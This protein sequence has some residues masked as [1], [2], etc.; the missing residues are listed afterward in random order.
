MS[1]NFITDIIDADI[2]AGLDSARVATRFPPEPNG[3][4]HIGHAKS[5]CLNFG[6]AQR[7]GGRCHLRFD[8]TNPA[9]EDIAYVTSIQEDVRWLGFDWGEHLYFASDWFERIFEIAL[10]LVDSGDAYV[11]SQD[12][13]TI[14]AQR[15]GFGKPGVNSPFRD[16]S[17]AENRDLLLRMRAGEFADGTH[18]LR[19]RI[20]MTHPNMVLRDPLLYRIRH[21]THHRTGDDWCIYP[22]YDFAHCLEDAVEGITHSICTLEFE[23]NRALYDWVL[24]KVGGWDPRPRQYEFARLKLD[25]TV[26]SKRKLLRLVEDGTVSGWDDPRMPTIA[27]L[28]RRGVTPEAI[29]AF[30]E[31]VGVAKN[32]TVVDIGKLEYCIRQDLEATTPRAMAVLDPLPLELTNWPADK[33]DTLTLPWRQDG[34]AAREVTFGRHVLIEREDF[35]EAPPKK[36]RRLAPGGEVRLMGAYLV[37]CTGVT[38]DDTGRVVGLTGTVDLASRGGQAP[39]GRKVKGTLHWVDAATALPATVR[40]YDRLFKVAAPEGDPDVDYVDQLNPKSLTVAPL[41]RVERAVGSA[42]AATR[43]QFVRQGYFVADSVESRADALVFNRVIALRDSW[44]ATDVRDGRPARETAAAAKKKRADK[45]SQRKRPADVRAA[46]R[47]ANPTLAAAFADMQRTWGWSPS[48]ADLLSADAELVALVTDAVG[49]GA[50]PT[51]V[52]RWATNALLAHTKQHGVAGLRCTGA[53]FGQL[54]TLVDA[55]ALSKAAA[56]TVLG[57]LVA[58]GRDPAVLIEELGVAR[59]EDTGALGQV[60]ADIVAAHP[61]EAA[62]FAAGERQL[63]GFFMGQ[64]MR[65]TRGKADGQAVRAALQALLG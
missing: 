53:Q 1:S 16:R 40:L 55:G 14:R 36:W 28:R 43:F 51:S 17:V 13:D 46:A 20:D 48:D 42:A 25:Y 56:K 26:M 23:S 59:Q 12:V 33:S 30:A 6:L 39:D 41:A 29:R 24:D 3:F 11:D 54:V 2:D 47:E 8:D 50:S 62:R 45:P 44:G 65:A 19:A 32:N 60:V 64:A 57:E 38:K 15:G 34:D 22:M 27:G 21:V 18:V 35:S 58:T 37:R 4:L 31:L 5:I 52:A 10:K 49:A 63:L 7:Y 61:D 9:K